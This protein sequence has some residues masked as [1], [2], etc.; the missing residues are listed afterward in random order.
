MDYIHYNPVKHGY[1]ENPGIGR[2][3]LSGRPWRM[4][5][6]L[7]IGNGG[8]RKYFENGSG[9]G[10]RRG[11]P[12]RPPTPPGIRF[13][14]KAVPAKPLCFCLIACLL[15]SAQPYLADSVRYL[16]P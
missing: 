16:Q 7:R 12:R 15:I 11:Y 14:T 5:C 6:M 4:D 1:V 13:R 3:A 2:T 10:R 9:S 8:T